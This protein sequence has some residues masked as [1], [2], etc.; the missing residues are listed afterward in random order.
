MDLL[1]IVVKK[2]AEVA[3][4]TEGAEDRESLSRFSSRVSK[5]RGEGPMSSSA[6]PEVTLEVVSINIQDIEVPS[7]YAR[8]VTGDVSSLAASIK[9]YGIQQPI[10]V[11]KIKGS[12]KYRLVFG[13][14]RL[15]AAQV[16][17]F[18]AVPCIVELVT[19]EDRM[20]ILAL[21]ENMHRSPLSPL[22]Q[23]QTF[24]ELKK[25]GVTL[26]DIASNLEI[27]M[28]KIKELV[29][30][31]ELPEAVRKEVAK[32]P[33]QFSIAILKLL[34]S[35]YQKSQELGKTLFNAVLAGNVTNPKEAQTFLATHK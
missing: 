10:K 21:A 3:A 18:E 29:E 4:G 33:E 30:L 20:Q 25:G 9:T 17:G 34:R 6:E 11:V 5:L 35:T 22:E 13:R 14:R 26:H 28:E 12:K 31:L 23:G 16:A 1:R 32:N 27:S 7:N 24:E 8:Q 19:R 2:R 15:E